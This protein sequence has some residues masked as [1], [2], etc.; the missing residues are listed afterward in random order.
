MFSHFQPLIN[1]YVGKYLTHFYAC[2]VEAQQACL[3]M[4]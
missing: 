2:S 3:Y 4:S 1:N